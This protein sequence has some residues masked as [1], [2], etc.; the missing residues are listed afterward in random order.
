MFCYYIPNLKNKEK[1]Y[2][3]ISSHIQYVENFIYLFLSF[4]EVPK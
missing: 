3:A 2:L 4:G 1:H